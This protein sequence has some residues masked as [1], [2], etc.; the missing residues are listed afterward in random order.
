M[1]YLF[2]LINDQQ[3]ILQKVCTEEQKTNHIYANA[4][5]LISGIVGISNLAF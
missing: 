3:K 1:Y 4:A 2:H 5:C